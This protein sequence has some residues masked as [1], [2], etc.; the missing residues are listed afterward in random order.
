M[1]SPQRLALSG[2][3]ILGGGTGQRLGGASKPDLVVRG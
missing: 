3:V 2:L 1:D